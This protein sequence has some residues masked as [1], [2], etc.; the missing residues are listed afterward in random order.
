MESLYSKALHPKL[1]RKRRK[2][3]KERKEVTK[4][5]REEHVFGEV[6]LQHGREALQY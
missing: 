4:N 1:K 5:W 3:R 6:L 2:E